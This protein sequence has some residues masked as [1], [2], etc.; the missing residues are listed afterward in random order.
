MLDHPAVGGDPQGPLRMGG[1]E[2][3]ATPPALVALHAP[4]E[5]LDDDRGAVLADTG[6]LVAEDHPGA[7]VDVHEVGRTDA[8]RLH[9]QELATAGR[10]VELDDVD[11]PLGAAHRLH[12]AAFTGPPSLGRLY[13]APS[14]SLWTARQYSTVWS[15]SAGGGRVRC[16]RGAE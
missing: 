8:R 14:R 5:R 4:V 2:V 3:V 13:L 16:H 10:L 11:A 12:W 9:R 1:A 6:Q 7:E 15:L